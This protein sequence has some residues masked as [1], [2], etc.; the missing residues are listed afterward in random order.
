MLERCLSRPTAS[1]RTRSR[2]NM[3][4][5]CL[6]RVDVRVDSMHPSC[7]Y[8]SDCINACE[9]VILE[10]FCGAAG[11]TSSLKG[12][13]TVNIIPLEIAKVLKREVPGVFVAPPCGTASMACSIPNSGDMGAPWPLRT[14]EKMPDGIEGLKESNYLPSLQTFSTNALC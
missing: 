8:L 4:R 2:K 10:I 7:P 1:N 9:A 12:R 6:P 5:K 3:P 11:V 14:L 13:V